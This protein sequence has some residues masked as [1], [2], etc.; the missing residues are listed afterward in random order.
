MSG[1][2]QH[3]TAPTVDPHRENRRIR[4]ND[5]LQTQGEYT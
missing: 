1:G 5:E 2:R 3:A 4:F